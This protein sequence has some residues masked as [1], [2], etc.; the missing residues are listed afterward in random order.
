MQPHSH[1]TPVVVLTGASSGIGRATAQAL[2]A[3]GSRLVLAAR[4]RRTLDIVAAECGERGAAVLVVP[5]DVT[6]GEAVAALASAA[7]ATFGHIDV[8]INNVGVGVV[9]LFDEVPMS[10]HRRVV[11]SNLLGHMHG[12]HA[13]LTHFRHRGRG[14]LINMIS[15]GGWVPAPYAAAYTASKFALR[16]F[17]E[18]IRAEVSSLPDVHV[19]AVAPT[20]VDSP[21]VG[22]GADRV[23][24]RMRPP[25]PMVDPREVARAIVA[26]VDAPRATVMVGSVAGPARL[27]HALAPELTGRLGLRAMEAALARAERQQTRDG[28]LFQPSVGTEI[29]GGYRQRGSG[30][31]LAGALIGIAA[32]GLQWLCTRQPR[33]TAAREA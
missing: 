28:N 15:L 3:R 17:T 30:V 7:I 11:E 18:S 32:I 13:A 27:A 20:F 22:H 5:T 26:L 2:A 23:G 19:C 6:D 31:L 1:S 4:D 16:G 10:L 29:D 33:G 12:T 25:S 24:R 8:W 9:G 21:G 14:T